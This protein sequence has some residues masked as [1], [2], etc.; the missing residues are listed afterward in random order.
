MS[1]D[2]FNQRLEST[3]GTWIKMNDEG[4]EA[5][6]ELVSLEYRDL[7]NMQGEL[8]K[9][10]KGNQR[11]ELIVTIRIDEDER[12][13][14]DDDG[15]RKFSLKES[16]QYALA[17]AIKQSGKKAEQG[18]RVGMRCLGR[19]DSMSQPDYEAGYKPPVVVTRTASSL[20]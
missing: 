19:K 12:T 6:G 3:G 8:V 1:M 2:D 5:R 9:S 20:V 16:G 7:R 15:I 18:G 13:D 11:V 14:A 17:A 4:N 10:K